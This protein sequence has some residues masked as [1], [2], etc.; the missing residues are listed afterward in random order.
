MEPTLF[1]PAEL[2]VEGYARTVAWIQESWL[3]MGVK[4]TPRLTESNRYHPVFQADVVSKR[5]H[6]AIATQNQ[7]QPPIPRA[8]LYKNVPQALS[9]EQYTFS[10]KHPPRNQPFPSPTPLVKH[11]H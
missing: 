8:E 9:R 2:E 7:V 6:H 5:R 10:I 3:A 4:L 11:L 1:Y